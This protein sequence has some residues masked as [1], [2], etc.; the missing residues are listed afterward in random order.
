MKDTTHHNYFHIVNVNYATKN[1]HN[2]MHG[3]FSL[4]HSVGG[5]Y[6]L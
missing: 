5:A 4:E 3:E 1:A 2:M 6:V